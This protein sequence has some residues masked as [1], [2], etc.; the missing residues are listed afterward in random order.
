MVQ[1]DG[2]HIELRSKRNDP[3]PPNLAATGPRIAQQHRP[4]RRSRWARV[5]VDMDVGPHGFPSAGSGESEQHH[6]EQQSHGDTGDTVE[7][8]DHGKP[9]DPTPIANTQAPNARRKPRVD[10]AN[11][12]PSTATPSP[13]TPSS[14]FSPLPISTPTRI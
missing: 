11:Q 10:T 12:A 14:T 5:D 6:D 8:A 4:L 3:E 1:H 13:S 9:D 7:C 2:L